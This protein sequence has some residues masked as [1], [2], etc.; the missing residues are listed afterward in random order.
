M[1]RRSSHK[2]IWVISLLLFAVAITAAPAYI[3]L[4]HKLAQVKV[5]STSKQV[6]SK[7]TAT[8]DSD[9]ASR[10]GNSSSPASDKS[11]SGPPTQGTT[12]ALVSPSGNFVSN[13]KPGQNGAPNSET[14][15]CDTTPGASCYI[16]FTNNDTT[17]KLDAQT[18]SADGVAIWYWNVKDAGFSAGSWKVSAVATFNGQTQTSNDVVTLEINP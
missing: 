12:A 15:V 10:A 3:H 8:S 17:K 13:H 14:S 7:Q 5:P 6:A 2:P 11:Q 18:A 1:N 9:S 4:H 16:Q